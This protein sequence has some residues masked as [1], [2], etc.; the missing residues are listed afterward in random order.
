[1]AWGRSPAIQGHRS[2][3][4]GAFGGVGGNRGPNVSEFIIVY[5]QH[6]E[7]LKQTVEQKKDT[8]CLLLGTSA[9]AIVCSR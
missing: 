2:D 7:Q 5:S 4:Q 3:V 6:F 9:T 8:D 1:M